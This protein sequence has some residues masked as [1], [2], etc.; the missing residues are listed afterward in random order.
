MQYCGSRRVQHDICQVSVIHRR[1]FAEGLGVCAVDRRCR[2]EM[3]FQRHAAALGMQTRNEVRRY[4]VEVYAHFYYVFLSRLMRAA[5]LPIRFGMFDHESAAVL[6]A[7]RAAG[8]GAD[9]RKLYAKLWRL[10]QRY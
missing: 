5:Y 9:R 3:R 6:A 10:R 1:Q 7:S 8:C 2:R 4:N